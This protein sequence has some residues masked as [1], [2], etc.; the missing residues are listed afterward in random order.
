ML[1]SRLL[2]SITIRK[3]NEV[4]RAPVV[5][6]RLGELVAARRARLRHPGIRHHG[7]FLYPELR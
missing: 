7:A 1:M 6:R 5:E 2:F 4:I 3:E